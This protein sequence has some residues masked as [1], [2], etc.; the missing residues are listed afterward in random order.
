[1]PGRLDPLVLFPRFT[2]LSGAGGTEFKT[3]PLDV[4]DHSNVIINVWRG[5]IVGGSGTLVSTCQ[6]STDQINWTTCGG[7]TAELVHAEDEETQI[8][9]HLQKR[10]FRFVLKLTA[11]SLTCWAVGSL[12]RR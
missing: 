6:E 1:M 4:N 12:E 10:W 2:A 11:A 7:T 8:V 9:A 5:A 3:V